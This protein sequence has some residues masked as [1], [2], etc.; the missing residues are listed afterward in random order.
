M[1]FKKTWIEEYLVDHTNAWSKTTHRDRTSLFKALLDRVGKQ[2]KPKDILQTLNSHYK[3]Y[4]VQTIWM[5]MSHYYGWLIDTNKKRGE[6][7]FTKYRRRNA[8][9]FK[10]KYTRKPVAVDFDEAARRIQHLEDGDVVRAAE[11]MLRSGLRI[12]ELN[13]IQDG[14]VIGKG[15]R[16]RR[17]FGSDESNIDRSNSTIRAKLAEVGLKPHDLRK[18]F[19]TKLAQ[20]GFRPEDLME[21]MGHS[22]YQTTLIYTQPQKDEALKKEISALVGGA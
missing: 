5:I 8:M 16:S 3:P 20:G 22:S 6:N 13:T 12:S 19:A 1:I 4:S 7:V 2:T 15:G 21:V 14:V 17:Y 18:L 11:R 9:L 10:N